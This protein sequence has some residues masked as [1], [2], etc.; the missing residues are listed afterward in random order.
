MGFAFTVS[1]SLFTGWV[2]NIFAIILCISMTYFFAKVINAKTRSQL[3]LPLISLNLGI[4]LA[5]L[6]FN[7][8]ESFFWTQDAIVTHIPQSTKFTNFFLGRGQLSSE[9]IQGTTTHFLNGALFAILGK[10]I[11]ASTLAQLIFKC[12]A[13]YAIYEIAIILWCPRV[14][15]LAV[16]LYAFSPNNFFYTVVF[17]KE[18]AVQA[19]YA[20]ILL[21]ALKIFIQK[22]FLHIILLTISIILLNSERF[23]LAYLLLPMLV[24]LAVYYFARPNWK[25]LVILTI[26]SAFI[27]FMILTSKYYDLNIHGIIEAIQIKRAQYSS[28]SDVLN[29]YN[30]DIPYVLAFVKILLSPFFTFNK[31]KIFSDFSLLLIW[32]SPLNQL[33]IVTSVVGLY[34]A[35]KRS[36]VHL[37]L[38]VPFVLFLLL[39]AYISPWS[40]RLRDSFY[41]LISI[42][43]AF[44]L[45]NN[46]YFR[47]YFITNEKEKNII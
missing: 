15:T 31:F 16:C 27:V 11:F 41:P 24:F 10:G 29:K 22:K 33:I 39:A 2:Q 36:F 23:Y 38:W 17:Y 20:L 34:Q 42:Y 40:G 19:L 8:P 37:I 5:T 1:N 43:A 47:K 30:Y 13:L 21:S 25:Q 3:Y 26:L 18:S 35:C 28:Y 12:L 9:I 4:L 32:G 46:K 6:F 44:Y 14:A 45:H 7:I